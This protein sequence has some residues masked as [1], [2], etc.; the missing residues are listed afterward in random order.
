MGRVG[1]QDPTCQVG[2]LGVVA[3]K[4]FFDAAL[5]LVTQ[6]QRRADERARIIATTARP[7]PLHH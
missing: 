1:R 3:G 5:G 6:F 2:P 7:L 4:L